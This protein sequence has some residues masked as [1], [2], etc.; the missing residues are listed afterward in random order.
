[1]NDLLAIIVILAFLV[2]SGAVVYLHR[3]TKKAQWT[4]I[5]IPQHVADKIGRTANRVG[6]TKP[7]A[8]A[9]AI[10]FFSRLPLPDK[11]QLCRTYLEE[12]VSSEDEA[13]S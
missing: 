13:A 7:T 4:T 1:M 5:R 8:I 6:V 11:A 2:V 10:W 3:P 9:A 12:G